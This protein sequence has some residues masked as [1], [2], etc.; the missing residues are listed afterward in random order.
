[1]ETVLKLKFTQHQDLKQMLLN[2]GD[3]ELVEVCQ[4]HH[5]S[6]CRVHHFFKKKK[7]SPR[8]WFWG[9]GADGTGNNELGK[10]L[11]RLRGELRMFP[12]LV[13]SLVCDAQE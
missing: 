6:T 12:F 10:A 11:M 4:Y 3:A 7:D 2:T 8:D 1:M 5:P 9:I 13:T